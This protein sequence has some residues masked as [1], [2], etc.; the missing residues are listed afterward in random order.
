MKAPHANLKLWGYPSHFLRSRFNITERDLERYLDE[1]LSRAATT[2]T[3]ISNTWPPAQSAW[4]NPSSRA[5][6]R[7]F[8]SAS[9]CASSAGER[10]GYAYSDDLSPEK[11]LKA[12]RV[13][14]CIAAGPATVE[15]IPLAGRSAPQSLSRDHGAHRDRLRRACRAGQARRQVRPRLRSARLSGAGHLRRQPAPR[16]GRHQRRRP[17]FRPPADGAPERARAGAPGR[18]RR[19]RAAM[20]AAADASA[21]ISFSTKRRPNTSPQKPRGRPSCS[22]TPSKPP[23]AR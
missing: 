2:P 7:A 11:I 17:Q 4:T 15:K 6:R 21:S 16:D 23:P 9:A 13:A 5:P 14:A 12:A 3:S 1:A 8:R 18:R 19:R 20:P 10:T 22:W